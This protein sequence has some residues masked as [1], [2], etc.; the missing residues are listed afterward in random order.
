MKSTRP[1]TSLIEL[2]FIP[3]T[4]IGHTIIMDTTK[5]G[6]FSGVIGALAS[7]IPGFLEKNVFRIAKLN[8]LDYAA[9]LILGHEA[10][11]I[12]NWL[13]AAVGHVVFGAALGVCFVF[14]IK[15]PL[16]KA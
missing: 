3:L 14:F 1:G 6:A 9:A 7:I 2:T 13:M 4:Q 10:T 8:F 5:L 12:W 15:K 16:M 11:D